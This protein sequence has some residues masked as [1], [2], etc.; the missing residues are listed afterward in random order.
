M[1]ILALKLAEL[2]F[3]KEKTQESS[4]SAEASADKPVLLLDDIFSEFD[5]EHREVVMGV[6]GRQQTIV[7]ATETGIINKRFLRNILTIEL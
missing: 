1:A 7:T 4:A 6:L 2:S 5:K 3:I